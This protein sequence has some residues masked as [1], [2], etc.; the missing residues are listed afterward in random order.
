MIRRRKRSKKIIT[1]DHGGFAGVQPSA[2]QATPADIRS[3]ELSSLA[4]YRSPMRALSAELTFKKQPLAKQPDK[5]KKR[6]SCKCKKLTE[7]GV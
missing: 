7:Q 1:S 2:T 3:S 5:T 6:L 4:Q